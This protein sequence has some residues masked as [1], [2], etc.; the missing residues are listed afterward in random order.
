MRAAA[1]PEMCLKRSNV[2]RR[3][4]LVNVERHCGAWWG[5]DGTGARGREEL[6]MREFHG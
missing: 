5:W 3:H 4:D 1:A 2:K 6:L